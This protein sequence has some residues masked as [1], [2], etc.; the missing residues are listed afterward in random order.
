MDGKLCRKSSGMKK[1]VRSQVAN[2]FSSRHWTPAKLIQV[3][4]IFEILCFWNFEHAAYYSLP[5]ARRRGKGYSD[6]QFRISVCIYVTTLQ[7]YCLHDNSKNTGAIS[8]IYV[9]ILG[10]HGQHEFA[11][12]FSGC[13]RSHAARDPCS[14]SA[15]VSKLSMWSLNQ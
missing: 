12:G 2:D 13:T 10:T 15:L 7:S 6:K 3:V 5:T 4:K 11:F 9:G 14:S 1:V 8:S